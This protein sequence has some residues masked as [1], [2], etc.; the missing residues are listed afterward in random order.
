[1]DDDINDYIGED[2]ENGEGV[3]NKKDLIDANK[4]R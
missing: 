3:N 1:M 4:N 2:D